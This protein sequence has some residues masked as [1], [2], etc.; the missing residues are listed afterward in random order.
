MWRD[1]WA[2]EDHGKSFEAIFERDHPPGFRYVYE[3]FGTNWR[4]TEIQAAIGR[5]QIPTLPTWHARRQAVGS[6]I[7]ASLRALPAL[8]V[9]N[10]PLHG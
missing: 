5:I 8:R 9:L 2:Y 10:G 3:S 7:D 6:R 1:A 4:I